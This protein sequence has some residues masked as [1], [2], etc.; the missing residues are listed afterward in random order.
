MRPQRSSSGWVNWTTSHCPSAVFAL[1]G[2]FLLS[3]LSYED[4]NPVA[5]SWKLFCKNKPT[6]ISGTTC[7]MLLKAAT[8]A[9]P[10]LDSSRGSSARPNTL[11]NDGGR[12][13]ALRKQPARR[14]FIIL[15]RFWFSE[16][17]AK[18]CWIFTKIAARLRYLEVPRSCCDL[19]HQNNELV[20]YHGCLVK[21]WFGHDFRRCLE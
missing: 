12:Q 19:L 6:F 4:K 11:W 17:L 18:L 5:I 3:S 2:L 21:C 20:L 1:R 8:I 9:T 16:I 10:T 15:L 14:E 13:E 7:M